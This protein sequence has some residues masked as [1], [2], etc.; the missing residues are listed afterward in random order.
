MEAVE[1]S[2]AEMPVEAVAV[3]ELES[4]DHLSVMLAQQDT[5]ALTDSDI[6]SFLY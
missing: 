5:S 4:L 2:A 1:A 3:S 6:A